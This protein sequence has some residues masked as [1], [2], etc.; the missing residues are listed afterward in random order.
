MRG[1]AAAG[2]AWPGARGARAPRQRFSA[3][4]VLARG[5]QKLNTGACTDSAAA[6]HRFEAVALHGADRCGGNFVPL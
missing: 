3:A 1:I 2:S 4:V 6:L 5:H